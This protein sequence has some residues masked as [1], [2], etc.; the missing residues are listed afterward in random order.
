M[1]KGEGMFGCPIG[2]LKRIK[3]QKQPWGLHN[4]LLGNMKNYIYFKIKNF[5]FSYQLLFSKFLKDLIK[6]N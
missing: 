1:R 5:Y 2:L 4:C 6:S 3:A